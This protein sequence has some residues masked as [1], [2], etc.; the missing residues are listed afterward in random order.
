MKT[1]YLVR[2]GEVAPEFHRV[3]RGRRL[4]V[5]LSEN[6]LEMARQNVAWL[7][8]QG[9]DQLVT[10]GMQ[11]T[12]VA[13]LFAIDHGI[14]HV[15]DP[16]WAEADLGNWEGQHY[17]VVLQDLGEEGNDHFLDRP[18]TFVH[19]QVEPSHSL[20][21]RL[22]AAWLDLL[23]RPESTIA[24]MTHAYVKAFWL[25][26]LDPSAACGLRDLRLGSLSEV[27]VQPDGQVEIVRRGTIQFDPALLQG[28]GH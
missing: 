24:V 13:G 21:S 4:D 14:E 16:R 17:E 25:D 7:A 18:T 20:Q 27:R 6:G 19:P 22:S 10:S 15:V 2:H 28:D 26:T 12:D 5:P 9:V 3:I 23:A 8:K 1:I 11:R